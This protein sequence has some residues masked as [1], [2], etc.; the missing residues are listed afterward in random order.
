MIGMIGLDVQ[1]VG[2]GCWP[3][4]KE[5]GFIEGKLTG[6]ARMTGGTESGKSTFTVRVEL[7]DGQVVLA[8]TTMLL[9][10]TAVKAM[11]VRDEMEGR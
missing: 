5:K 7:P 1:L 4:L 9:M 3:D 6:V 11:T 8:E 10:K 2:D